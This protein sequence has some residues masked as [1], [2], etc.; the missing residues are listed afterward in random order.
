MS[1]IRKSRLSEVMTQ[2]WSY[3][4]R[5]GLSMSAALKR[6]WY[7]YKLYTEVMMRRA[8]KDAARAKKMRLQNNL[9]FNF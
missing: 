8:A 5:L 3:V 2:A 1:A 7:N 4:R 6:A 9:V